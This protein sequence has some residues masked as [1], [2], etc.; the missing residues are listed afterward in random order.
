MCGA[1]WGK[2]ERGV[3][4]GKANQNNTS[5]ARVLEQLGDLV[6]M[7]QCV[8]E[9]P[10]TQVCYNSKEV[11]QGCLFIC[12]GA[13]FSKTYLEEAK[14][15]GAVCYVAET[16]YDVDMDYVVVSDLRLALGKLVAHF[17]GDVSRQTKLIGITGTK[18]KSTTALFVRSIL[19]VM[20]QR[21]GKEKSG[22]LCSILTYDGKEELPSR[23]TT[24]EPIELY[25]HIQN[26]IDTN[27]SHI[28]MEVSSQA[29]K[30][31]RIYGLQF[32]LG[33]YLNIGEDHISPSEHPDFEDYFTSK[34]AFFQRCENVVVH[35]DGVC[36]DRVL[37]AVPQGVGCVTCSRHHS[38]ADYHV[39]SCGKQGVATEFS[40]HC[41]DFAH[42][43]EQFTIS[44]AGLFNVDNA[45]CAIALC[46]Q[47]G[48]TVEEIRE[49][50]RLGRS[51]GRMELYTSPDEKITVLVDYA[52]NKMSFQALFHSMKE[53]FPT[54][55]LVAVFG[56]PGN[57]ALDRR[58]DMGRI[59]DQFADFTILTEDDPA[60]ES[61]EDICKEIGRSMPRKQ[62][63]I[64]PD[65]SLAVRQ[66]M[67]QFLDQEVLVL[68]LGKGT[69][70][71][72]KRGTGYE[73]MPTDG[74]TAQACLEAYQ[75]G[76]L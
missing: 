51:P 71:D 5:V 68:L 34:L 32:A 29:V 8:G 22:I 3:D 50:L 61:V 65:R 44:M 17:Y 40:V 56:C 43:T 49:G 69:E 7:T 62:W 11:E 70:S 14:Q 16:M 31:H 46:H 66:A 59:A 75:R 48:A 4:V 10:L 53:E 47:L 35:L 72:Q 60:K 19:D 64:E 38:N 76:E 23:L 55:K 39:T 15:R 24:K 20:L 58:E 2:M 67:T 27:V 12:K 1:V 74:E 26:A 42:E 41:K 25:T 33:C 57:K 28:T 13:N 45:V 21:R 54:K 9:T 18:G 6:E 36:T 73:E 52:H 30:Y 63:A 37:Q